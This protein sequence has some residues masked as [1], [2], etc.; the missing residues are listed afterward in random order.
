MLP[1]EHKMNSLDMHTCQP[2]GSLLATIICETESKG[3]EGFSFRKKIK[4]IVVKEK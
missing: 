4:K 1:D 3:R 2:A